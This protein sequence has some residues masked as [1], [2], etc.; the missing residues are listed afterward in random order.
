MSYTILKIKIILSGHELVN[1]QELKKSNNNKR[2][3]TKQFE[4]F[5][6]DYFEQNKLP[7][8][9]ADNL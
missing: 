1:C 3:K 5:F 9:A 7:V 8:A 6:M 2:E 4:N